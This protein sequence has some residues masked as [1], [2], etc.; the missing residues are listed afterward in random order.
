MQSATSSVPSAASSAKRLFV[1]QE[2]LV[3]LGGAAL[4]SAAL[5]SPVPLLLGAAGELLWLSLGSLSPAVRHWVERRE[6]SQRRLPAPATAPETNEPS[7]QRVLA[8]EYA[9]RVLT[10][11]RALTTLRTFGGARPEPPFELAVSRL[12]TIRPLYVGLCDTHQ[13]IGRFLAGTREAQLV[14]EA[15]RLK[16]QFAG[17]KDLGTRLTLKQAIG[18]AQ[19]RVTHR[20]EMVELQRSIGVKLDSVERSLAYLVSQGPALG[21]NPRLPDEVEALLVELGPALDVDVD[22]SRDSV[23]APPSV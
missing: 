8:P 21:S 22:G 20:R 4:F 11:D 16:V 5:A 7:S 23:P 15:E 6:V 2:N 17:E 9:G 12:R 14:A 3:L 13:R 10:L 19:R 18:A 1:V